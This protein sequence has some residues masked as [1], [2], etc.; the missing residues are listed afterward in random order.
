M[1]FLN[2]KNIDFN[3][4]EKLLKSLPD[5]VD[6]KSIL[7]NSKNQIVVQMKKR[8]FYRTYNR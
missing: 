6:V 8:N 7:F 5:D 1:I 4:I 3:D 2:V